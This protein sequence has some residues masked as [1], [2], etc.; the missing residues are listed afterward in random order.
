[1]NPRSCDKAPPGWRCTRMYLHEGPCAAIRDL[2]IALDVD[3]VLADFNGALSKALVQEG[4][5]YL[6]DADYNT[7]ELKKCV[8]VE[9]HPALDRIST[10][11]GFCSSI[12]RYPAAQAF[13]RILKRYGRVFALTTAWNGSTWEQ[14]RYAWLESFGF[15]DPEIQIVHSHDEKRAVPCD[16]II[17][18]RLETLQDWPQNGCLKILLDRPWNQQ[19]PERDAK[20]GILRAA[21]YDGVLQHVEAKYGF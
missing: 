13:Y 17:E 18:D 12:E 8:P 16:V 2:N 3:G 4:G 9:W 5:P 10:R 15:A 20:H 11:P 14:E 6:A 19:S 21:D 7:W 1:M